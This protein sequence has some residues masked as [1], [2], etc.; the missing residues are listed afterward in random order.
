MKNGETEVPQVGKM[1]KRYFEM[2]KIFLLMLFAAFTMTGCVTLSTVGSTS[3]PHGLFGSAA[4]KKAVTSDATEVASYTVILGLV[5]SGY[6]DYV[7]KVK[8]AE[9]SGKKIT[10]TTTSYILV[11]KTTA[12]AR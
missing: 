5:D 10:S 3:D 11:S 2:K 1:L 7:A 12:F 8:K 9:A 4:T 6:E